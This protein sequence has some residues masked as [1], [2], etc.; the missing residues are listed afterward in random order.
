MAMRIGSYKQETVQEVFDSIVIGSGMGGMTV[1]ALLARHAGQRV[2]VLERHYTPG[3]FTH[4]F[5]RPGYEWD[6][7]VHYVGRVT[8]LESSERAAFD[9]LAKAGFS[10]SRCP[11]FMTGS[12]S[13]G[14]N[15]TFLPGPS[16]S[17]PAYKSIFPPKD[18]PSTLISVPSGARPEKAAP[19]LRLK[20]CRGQSN[21]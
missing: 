13:E 10:G 16:V 7:G 18:G 17:G 4:S 3:G 14:V 9:Y 5:R 15:T 8:N 1:A 11:T 20:P 21:G 19:T 12:C 6:V 2:L